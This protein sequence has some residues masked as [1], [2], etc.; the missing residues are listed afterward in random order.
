MA[1]PQILRKTIWLIAAISCFF[2]QTAVAFA[3]KSPAPTIVI[4][5]P[6]SGSTVSG[7]IHAS[8]TAGAKLGVAQ[9]GVSVDGGA[10]STASGTTTWTWSWNSASVQNGT[11]TLSARVTDTAGNVATASRSIAVSNPVLDTTPP[12][13][14]VATPASQASVSGSVTV[15]GTASDNV[16]VASLSVSVDG[17]AA[18]HATGTTAWSFAWNTATVANGSHVVIAQALDAAGN[19]GTASVT[20]VVNNAPVDTT[21]PV[22]AISSP[23]AGGSVAGVVT[24]SGTAS[25][26]V[27]LAKVEVSV[28]GD[29]WSTAAGTSSWSWSWSTAPLVNGA[30]TLAARATDTGGLTTVAS[31]TVTVANV[32]APPNA[33]G[34]WVS[35]EGATI[36]VNSAGNWTINQI[37]QMLLAISAAP[38]DFAR[39]APDL[40]VDVQDSYPSQ[41]SISAGG[42][43]TSY[44]AYSATIL[45]MGVNSNFATM[46]DYTLAHEYG[47]AWGQYYLFLA[48][49]GNWTP[50]LDQ[51]WDNADGSVVL[52]QD[53]RL[54]SSPAWSK[55]EIVAEDYR[56]LFGSAA[57]ISEKPTDGNMYI[58]DPRN[59]PGLAAWLLT[60]WRG[61]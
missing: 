60:T 40:T 37:Y 17:G 53:P 45:L 26:N 32:A 50:Y 25:D 48:H 55:T 9:V 43:G 2:V 27:G 58:P 39:I 42:N 47:H 21:P 10:W 18:T 61:M 28:D 46:P 6:S 24:V 3:A 4:S 29:A 15:S 56:L 7:V 20:V 12:T 19:S 44:S 35:P 38:G 23:A 34:T 41:T 13:I 52:A 33:Q 36:I 30:H 31:T 51:R 11:H 8:G 49:Q 57:S 5:A 59:Q 22:V 1:R 14:S 54:E 16:G